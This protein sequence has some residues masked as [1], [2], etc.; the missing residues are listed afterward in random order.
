MRRACREHQ[1]FYSALLDS[2]AVLGL[3]EQSGGKFA[4]SPMT[5]QYLVKGKQEYVGDHALHH[6]NT[7]ASWGRLDE[8]IKEG[9][10][11]PAVRD[12]LR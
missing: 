1:S 6:T 5:S 11:L 7:W 9:K 4:N 10:T 3:L 12:W 2:C 8:V